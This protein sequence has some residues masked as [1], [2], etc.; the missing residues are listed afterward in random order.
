MQ[1]YDG[2][3]NSSIVV[4]EGDGV[5]VMFFVCEIAHSTQ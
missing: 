3:F 1:F 5:A 2:A 4:G